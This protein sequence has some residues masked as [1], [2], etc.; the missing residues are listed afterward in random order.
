MI[1]REKRKIDVACSRRQEASQQTVTAGRRPHKCI[2]ARYRRDA[3]RKKCSP[4]PRGKGKW[5]KRRPQEKKNW[6]VPG[7]SQEGQVASMDKSRKGALTKDLK[8]L[9]ERDPFTEATSEPL[10]RTR[11]EVCEN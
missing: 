3:G 5:K 4:K 11:E 2:K 1:S 10:A 7:R 9:K 6:G 8:T